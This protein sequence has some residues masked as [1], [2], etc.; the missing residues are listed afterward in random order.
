LR[1]IRFLA[2]EN[3]NNAIVRGLRLRL[4]G[5][6][7]VR[8]QDEGLTGVE[9]PELLEWAAR[10]ERVLLTHDV[11]TI[12]H[13]A[14]QRIEAGQPMA[15][16]ARS[17]AAY[18]SAARSRILCWQPSTSNPASGRIRFDTCRFKR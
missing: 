3:F 7:I 8:A 13:F 15:G 12:P 2:D 17:P 18:R 4:P 5:V 10:E 1:V 14:Y 11:A 16:S 6:D 9:D